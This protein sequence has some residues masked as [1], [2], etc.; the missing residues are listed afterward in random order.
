MGRCRSFVLAFVLIAAFA[1]PAKADFVGFV[2][3]ETGTLGD[4]G[5]FFWGAPT[6]RS[7]PGDRRQCQPDRLFALEMPGPPTT[8]THADLA[9]WCRWMV[10]GPWDL[11]GF[12]TWQ[13][14]SWITS[15]G[16]ANDYAFNQF[17]RQHIPDRH[18]AARGLIS[19][20]LRHSSWN[21]FRRI[22]WLPS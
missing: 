2:Q 21:L 4:S 9:P 8:A 3:L 20:G 5:H 18:A 1:L 22:P 16:S 12:V 19:Q 11:Y 13:G 6:P 7:R 15:D 10:V 14:N 17:Q